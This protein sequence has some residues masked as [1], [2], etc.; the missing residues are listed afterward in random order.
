MDDKKASING[1]NQELD[2]LATQDEGPNIKRKHLDKKEKS[3]EN[4]G[5][6]PRTPFQRDKDRIIYSKA[7][8]RLIHKTQVCFTGEM[9]EHIRTRLTHTLEV[10]QIARSIALQVHANED[11][12]E[13]I[14]LGHDLGHTPFGHTGEKVLDEFLSGKDKGIK[15]KL[16]EMYEFDIT[17]ME[18]HFKH[19]F[20][21]VRVLSELEEGYK[22]LE[23]NDIK[24]LNLTYPVLEGILKHTTL[25]NG[26]SIVY[27]SIN[28]NP[29]FHI[30]QPFSCSL[31]GQI[32]ALADEIAQV[33]HDIEDAVEGNYDSK[34]LICGQLKM[35]ITN[36]S[37]NIRG[38]EDKK[39]VKK[40]IKAHHIKYIIS[41]I[42]GEVIS[43]AVDN[44]K[45]NMQELN[46]SGLKYPLNEEIA[47]HNRILE[48]DK[49]YKR[50]KEIE[51]N[52]VINNYKIDRMNGKS[53]FVLR[54]IIKAYLTNPKQL[55]DHV[56]EL[57]AEVCSVPTLK[58]LIKHINSNDSTPKNIR[59]LNKEIFEDN[60]KYIIRDKAF[61]RLL[62]DYIAS[63]TDLYALQQY[64]KLYGG[65]SI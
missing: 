58:E 40:M 14:A 3:D 2:P 11:L 25:K 27:E 64:Q 38:L 36:K 41:C 61:L 43:T 30:G 26:H 28:D 44:I 29:Y 55:P 34:E 37:T 4:T 32:V 53:R 46:D 21:S 6:A 35:L 33:C 12:T 47:T 48:H 20:Q 54:Q 63:M 59:Y 52:L 19:N 9:N 31:E 7:F 57:Y 10:S 17:E 22:D 49:L 60:Q 65:D 42:I 16:Q 23:N 39:D 51:D 56:L 5:I 1:K 45:K 8:R 24:G 18:L 62:S 15:N 50:L 13:A